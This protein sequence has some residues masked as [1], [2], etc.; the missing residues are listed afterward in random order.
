MHHN[1]RD[2]MTPGAGAAVVDRRGVRHVESARA[3][4]MLAFLLAAGALF[5]D[6]PGAAP[7][8]RGAAPGVAD[9]PEAAI[10]T[11]E[12]ARWIRDARPGLRVLDIRDAGE[13]E[14]YHIPTALHVPRGDLPSAAPEPGETVVLYTD[15]DQ[16]AADAVAELRA[17]G[18]DQVFWLHEGLAG[19]ADRILEPTLRADATEAERAA[20]RDVSD[21]ARWFG[22]VPR[23]DAGAPVTATPAVSASARVKAIRRG[24]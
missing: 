9:V 17:R 18:Y 8:A 14:A 11:I 5:V 3:L 13:F 15:G 10:G 20:F 23:T 2:G 24:C 6:P 22:G 7:T 12:L 4:G 1:A 19:W 16:P 21:L